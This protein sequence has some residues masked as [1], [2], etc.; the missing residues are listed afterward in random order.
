[1]PTPHPRLREAIPALPAR[2]VDTA[3]AFYQQRLGFEHL[4]TMDGYAGVRRGDVELHLWT[5]DGEATSG[6]SCRVN[7]SGIEALYAEMRQAGVI[8]P[9]GTLAAK[10]W[11]YRE[12]AVLDADG[13][14]ITFAEEMPTP[15]HRT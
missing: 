8:S 1:M 12:F 15:G 14:Q 6:G 2:N 13:N 5:R 7:V 11:G 10:A 9:D 3:V 4:F